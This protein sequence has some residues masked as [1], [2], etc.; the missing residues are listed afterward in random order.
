MLKSHAIFML[1]GTPTA[2]AQAVRV[3]T[4]A[5]AQWPDKLSDRIA[6]RVLAALARKHLPAEML[7][8]CLSDLPGQMPRGSDAV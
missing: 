7:A 2:V 3:S 6:D 8:G 4:S 1:G 5:V